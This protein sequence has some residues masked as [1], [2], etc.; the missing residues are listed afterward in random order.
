MAFAYSVRFMRCTAGGG[1]FGS[2]GGS[3]IQF[4]FQSNR[5]GF[6][7]RGIGPRHTLRGHH[8]RA[9]FAD[10]LLPGL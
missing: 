6:V 2:G 4:V 1:K 3:A 9:Q 10:D 5:D 7:R 8:S